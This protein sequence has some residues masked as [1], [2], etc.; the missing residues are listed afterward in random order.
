[1]RYEVEDLQNSSKPSINHEKMNL[2]KNKTRIFRKLKHEQANKDRG[3][4]KYEQD[5]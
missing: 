2:K 4:R 5:T 3:T 1:M